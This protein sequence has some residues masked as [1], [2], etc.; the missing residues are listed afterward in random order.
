MS[1]TIS[2]SQVEDFLYH[3]AALLDAWR[4]DEWLTL[5]TPD[6]IYRV[7]SNDRPRGDPKDTLF[8][9][10]D[11]IERIHA[12]VVR[13]KDPDAH[14]E[15]PHS[16]TRRLITNVR[17]IEASDSLKVESIKVESIKVEANFSVH[18]FRRD[19]GHREYVGHYCYELRLT[20]GEKAPGGLK[21]ARREAVL[22][23][24]EL[25]S[26]GLVSFIL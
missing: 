25:G 8:L 4:L 18:R 16:R 14:A 2:R 7:P 5:L 17:L 3:E 1:A 11:N 19:G 15:H 6:A 9:I 13:L 21:I 26:L 12:R 23:P 24:H 10:A 20:T 22:D